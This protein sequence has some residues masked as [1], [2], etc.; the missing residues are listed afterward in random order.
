ML[1][2][3]LVL[4]VSL[5]FQPKIKRKVEVIGSRLQPKGEMFEPESGQLVDWL[6]ELDE[7]KTD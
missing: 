5:Y 1:V 7:N 6:K 2:S 3:L 4:I